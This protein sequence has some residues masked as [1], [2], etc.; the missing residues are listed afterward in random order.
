MSDMTQFREESVHVIESRNL[1]CYASTSLLIV[2]LVNVGD[3]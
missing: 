2:T 1:G 3:L